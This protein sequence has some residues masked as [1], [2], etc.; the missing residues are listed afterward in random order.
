MPPSLAIPCLQLTDVVGELA[1]SISSRAASGKNY[2]VV[3]VPEGAIA[4]IPE[5]RGLIAGE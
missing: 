5:I 4:Y 3:L 1:D 2:G